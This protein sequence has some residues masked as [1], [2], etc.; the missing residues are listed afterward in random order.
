M[1][2]D[3]FSWAKSSNPQYR[4]KQ[5]MAFDVE[6]NSALIK[7]KRRMWEVSR[8]TAQYLCDSRYMTVHGCLSAMKQQQ[9]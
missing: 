6:M 9:R 3:E 5:I 4:R 7:W 2:H 8:V 1:P